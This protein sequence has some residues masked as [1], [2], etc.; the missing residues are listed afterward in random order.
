MLVERDVEGKT[1]TKQQKAEGKPW[2]GCHSPA[3]GAV[4]GLS[5]SPIG[6]DHTSGSEKGPHPDPPDATSNAC[7]VKL[8]PRSRATTSPG[9]SMSGTS[10]RHVAAAGGPCAAT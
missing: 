2:P 3:A 7:P 8:Q 9:Q 10:R 6:Q 4:V 5:T 1:P